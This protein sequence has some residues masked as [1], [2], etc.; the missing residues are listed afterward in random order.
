[1]SMSKGPYENHYYHLGDVIRGTVRDAQELMYDLEYS[2]ICRKMYEY[3]WKRRDKWANYQPQYPQSLGELCIELAQNSLVYTD[4]TAIPDGWVKT[5]YFRRGLQRDIQELREKMWH[6][7]NI[8]EAEYHKHTDPERE[9]KR[10]KC[11]R[12][13]ELMRTA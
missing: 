13:I 11:E 1:M 2:M 12:L 4:V 7:A 3:R 9:H 10:A 5:T 6:R 8:G